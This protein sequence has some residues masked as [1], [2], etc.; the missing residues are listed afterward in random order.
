MLSEDFSLI[1]ATEDFF[2][3]ADMMGI[4]QK[5]KYS[6]SVT[7]VSKYLNPNLKYFT[8]RVNHQVGPIYRILPY[9]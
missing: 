4:K 3:V 1:M 6:G 8:P 9:R 7:V 2:N 5:D